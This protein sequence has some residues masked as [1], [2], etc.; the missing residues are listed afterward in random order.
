[1]MITTWQSGLKRVKPIS[2]DK[3]DEVL[4]AQSDGNVGPTLWHSLGFGQEELSSLTI[5]G[6]VSVS[7]NDSYIVKD[8]ITSMGFQSLSLYALSFKRPRFKHFPCVLLDSL[9]NEH[10]CSAKT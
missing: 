1:M 2:S 10:W 3:K 8:N 6:W 5:V 4:I 7:D 9:F